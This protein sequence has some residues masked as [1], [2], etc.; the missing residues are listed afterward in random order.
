VLGTM[1]MRRCTHG[2][3]GSVWSHAGTCLVD[4]LALLRARPDYA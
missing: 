3:T 2:G 4:T 1:L